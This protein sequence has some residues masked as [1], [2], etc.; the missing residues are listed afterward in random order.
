LKVTNSLDRL[1]YF[2]FETK[3]LCTTS[4][5]NQKIVSP[6]RNGTDLEMHSS[7]AVP[8]DGRS[9]KPYKDC[10]NRE[11]IDVILPTML[12]HQTQH[13]KVMIFDMILLYFMVS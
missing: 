10:E 5:D 9:P 13:A 7:N 2:R 11:V 3:H 4:Q 12:N 8:S 1:P 6:K